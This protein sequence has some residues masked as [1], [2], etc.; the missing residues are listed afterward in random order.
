MLLLVGSFLDAAVR[1]CER[2]RDIS[3]EDITGGSGQMVKFGGTWEGIEERS[4]SVSGWSGRWKSRKKTSA[5]P[6]SL[7]GNHW[8]YSITCATRRMQAMCRE[9]SRCSQWLCSGKFDFRSHPADDVLSPWAR[10]HEKGGIRPARISSQIA[11]MP[12]KTLKRFRVTP[13]CIPTRQSG[14]SSIRQPTPLIAQNPPSPCS[15]ASVR[16]T[17]VG[18]LKEIQSRRSANT[19][20]RSRICLPDPDNSRSQRRRLMKC[21]AVGMRKQT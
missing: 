14:G 9:A 13:S 18:V 19:C 1:G 12:P 21:R 7:P 5:V 15:E 11:T 3:Q 16:N 20:G 2:R 4:M 8:E 17:C 6:L 10:R